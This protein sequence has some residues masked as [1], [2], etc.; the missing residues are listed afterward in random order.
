M[1]PSAAPGVGGSGGDG[2][3]RTCVG[4]RRVAGRD[5][6]V[7]H[8]VVD[9]V[10]VVDPGRRLPGR[11]SW[12]HPDPACLAAAVKRGGFARSQRRPA[13]PSGLLSQR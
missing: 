5:E 12:L 4:C 6:L 7:R 10:V 9:G 11:G 1:L 3:I 8:V 2:P 13:D